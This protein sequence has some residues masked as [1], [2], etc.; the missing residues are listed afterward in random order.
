MVWMWRQLWFTL[1][2]RKRRTLIFFFAIKPDED[3]IVNYILWIDGRARRGYHAF[4]D[5]VIF[6]RTY[7]INKYCLPLGFFIGVNH[8]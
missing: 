2:K 7:N 1:N 5:V 4:G 8:H 3:G 6:G